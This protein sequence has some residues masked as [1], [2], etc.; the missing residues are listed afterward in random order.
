M[1]IIFLHW[2]KC[3]EKSCFVVYSFSKLC[4]CKNLSLER[5]FFEWNGNF[6]FF[7]YFSCFCCRSSPRTSTKLQKAEGG[8][9]VV[10]SSQLNSRSNCS[11]GSSNLAKSNDCWG[12]VR[13]C[14]LKLDWGVVLLLCPL[15]GVARGVICWIVDNVDTDDA[16]SDSSTK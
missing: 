1:K 5:N 16:S 10:T 11:K 13:S 7:T 12:L 15:V 9:K 3:D 14:V 4:A 2:N 6:F 8:F